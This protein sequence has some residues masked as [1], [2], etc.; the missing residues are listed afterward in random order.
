MSRIASGA[1]ATAHNSEVRVVIDINP[2]F[3][4]N[5]A[6]VDQHAP[7][8]ARPQTRLKQYFAEK[9]IQYFSVSNVGTTDEL[10]D[11]I[12]DYVGNNIGESEQFLVICDRV[13]GNMDSVL[14]PLNEQFAGICSK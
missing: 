10:S 14:G 9:G 12:R 11:A 5:T 3:R 4:A 13:P 6:F 7:G 1:E 8:D 2:D